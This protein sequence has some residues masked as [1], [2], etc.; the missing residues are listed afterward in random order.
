MK[1]IL[2]IILFVGSSAVS[3]AMQR[4][5]V[6]SPQDFVDKYVN[7]PQ[8]RPQRPV[9]QA[10]MCTYEVP[11]R[12]CARNKTFRV[13][14]DEQTIV[15]QPYFCTHCGG[16]NLVMSKKDFAKAIANRNQFLATNN[17]AQN[18]NGYAALLLGA[19]LMIVTVAKW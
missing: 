15:S 6:A 3:K 13:P 5:P 19:V 1:K 9:R 11:C 17:A 8:Y 4:Q 14:C 2:L 7:P 10:A 12:V 16:L 18:I